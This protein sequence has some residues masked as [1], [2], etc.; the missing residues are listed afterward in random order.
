MC[1]PNSP[2]L[3]AVDYAVW[4]ALQQ[5]VQHNR[6]FTTVDQL[7]H[8]HTLFIAKTKYKQY[9]TEYNKDMAGC[10]RGRGPSMLA[11]YGN[12]FN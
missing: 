2:D 5:Q 3:N 12:K 6:K 7:K 11:T 10:Q 4:G 9:N 8:T 1:P